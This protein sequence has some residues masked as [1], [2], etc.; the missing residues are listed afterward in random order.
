MD[1]KLKYNE[2]LLVEL[3]YSNRKKFGYITRITA[4]VIWIMCENII[5]RGV[6]LFYKKNSGFLTKSIY[7]DEDVRNDL[8]EN[9]FL[10]ILY[11]YK[12]ESGT[13]RYYLNN[14]INFRIHRLVYDQNK[15]RNKVMAKIEG[16]G[17]EVGNEIVTVNDEVEISNTTGV[18]VSFVEYELKKNGFSEKDIQIVNDLIAGYKLDSGKDNICVRNKVTKA[19]I[20]KLKNK[21][22]NIYK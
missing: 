10:D 14:A 15:S 16:K 1:V 8:F 20:I 11:K 3:I 9:V 7:T 13:F 2:K 22:K 17:R 4:N 6:K 19:Y 12:R 5:E 18:N 21:L